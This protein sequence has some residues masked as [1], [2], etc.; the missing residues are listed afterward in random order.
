MY[1]IL[2]SKKNIKKANVYWPYPDTG[3]KAVEEPQEHSQ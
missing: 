3:G 1:F 2:L